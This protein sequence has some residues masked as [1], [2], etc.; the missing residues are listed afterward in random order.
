MLRHLTWE[1]FHFRI[2]ASGSTPNVVRKINQQR[3][4]SVSH[5]RM[6]DAMERDCRSML[7]LSG[8]LDAGL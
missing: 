8:C 5:S 3:Y 4:D 2:W 7:A 1:F 6:I